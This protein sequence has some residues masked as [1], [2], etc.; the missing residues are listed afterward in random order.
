M[1]HD[2]PKTKNYETSVVYRGNTTI[3][4]PPGT[5]FP[6]IP[7]IAQLDYT[8]VDLSFIP[9]YNKTYNLVNTNGVQRSSVITRYSGPV[10]LTRPTYLAYDMSNNLYGTNFAQASVGIFD[11]TTGGFTTI[12]YFS[13]EPI[14]AQ[15]P[16]P[17]AIAVSPI[18]PR[19][20]YIITTN[21]EEN[22]T[23]FIKKVDLVTRRIFNVDITGSGFA[24]LSGLAFDASGF[25]YSCDVV[26]NNILRFEITSENTLNNNEPVG[27]G[28]AI[29]SIIASSFSGIN[30]PRDLTCDRYNNI[31]V[32]NTNENNILKITPAYDVTIISNTNLVNPYGIS[33]NYGNDM[34]YI[35]NYGVI[36]KD[37]PGTTLQPDRYTG[38]YLYVARISNDITE[39][40]FLSFSDI[41][42]PPP[43]RGYYYYSIATDLL[44]N[45]S[46]SAASANI[47]NT[48]P[49][50]S[51]FSLYDGYSAKGLPGRF[52]GGN[53][54]GG[55]SPNF[56]YINPITSV[57][58]D[59]SQ[60]YLYAAEYRSPF[61]TE[62]PFDDEYPV[63]PSGI[64]WK[65]DTTA[66]TGWNSPA[67]T[68]FYPTFPGGQGLPSDLALNNPTSIAF[69]GSGN[70]YVGNAVDNK[71]VVITSTANGAEVIITG[72][73]LT[74]PT[75]L[76]FDSS[77]N[78][79]LVNF[80]DNTLCKLEFSNT[81]TA[82]STEL[83]LVGSQLNKP[84]A[85]TFNS[86]FTKLF[87]ANQGSNNILLV[88]PISL[89]STIYNNPDSFVNLSSPSGLAYDDNTGI[90][91]IS[92]TGMN[93][94]AI[95]TNNGNVNDL[96][97]IDGSSVNVLPEDGKVEMITPQGLAI[98]VCSNIYVANYG[99]T[100]DAILK[101]TYDP[102]N[103]TIYNSQVNGVDEAKLLAFD[104]KTNYVYILPNL[105]SN[106]LSIVT[107]SNEVI[108]YGE[109]SA[110]TESLDFQ[111]TNAFD[112]NSQTY[113][114]EPYDP[115][116][117]LYVNGNLFDSSGPTSNLWSIIPDGANHYGDLAYWNARPVTITGYSIPAETSPDFS[118]TLTFNKGYP[119]TTTPMAY[120]TLP[121]IGGDVIVEIKLTDNTNAVIR[122]LPI[123]GYIGNY[124]PESVLFNNS[125][126]RM[127]I[128]GKY[129]P[130]GNPI[131]YYVD[132]FDDPLA[133]NLPAQPFITV[134]SVGTEGSGLSIIDRYNFIY[135]ATGFA[136]VRITDASGTGV[137]QV[138]DYPENT[139]FT[140][141]RCLV[142]NPNENSIIVS[143]VTGGV[144]QKIPLSFNFITDKSNTE[145]WGLELFENT[146]VVKETS[147]LVENTFVFSFDIYT[148]LIW[149]TPAEP[150]SGVDIAT[151]YFTTT[152]PAS[153]EGEPTPIYPGPTDRYYLRCNDTNISNIFCNNC[154]YNKTKFLSG[155]YPVSL[156]ISPLSYYTY[157]ALQNNTIS[158]INQLGVVENSYIGTQYG[159]QN[160][161]SMTLDASYNMYVLNK[162]INGTTITTN[163]FLT[164]I[165][166]ENEVISA[167][168]IVSGID[169]PID[170]VF[171]RTNNVYV[172]IL[173]GNTPDVRITRYSLDAIDIQGSAFV[174]PI[175]F[176]DLYDP[177]GICVDENVPDQILMYITNTTQSGSHEIKQFYL[178]SYQSVPQYTIASVASLQYKGYK[179]VNKNDGK[180]YVNNKDNNSIMVVYIPS[181]VYAPVPVYVVP[182]ASQDI[183]VPSDIDFDPSGNLYVVNSGTSP[184][185]S[186]ISKIYI[187]YFNFTG[188]NLSTNICTATS[189][190]NIGEETNI[191][192]NY[193]DRATDD[194]FS[195]PLPNP[196]LHVYD[197]DQ[198][199]RDAPEPDD[200]T[201]GG[202]TGG[203]D[204]G[205]D[206]SEPP[207]G[208]PPDED[209]LVPPDPGM[210]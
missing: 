25:M 131:L 178:E 204:T 117:L 136:W 205:G 79:Y 126:S 195:W 208:P 159:L 37:Y 107:P 116:I 197:P 17:V 59:S 113:F 171:D 104:E 68:I 75:G 185:N 106:Y 157:V 9:Q 190:Y 35:A 193:P 141:I 4:P 140:D 135:L 206:G 172:Y 201:G 55:G 165:T 5:G 40:Y 123:T 146:L 196:S 203:G 153:I 162:N 71:L 80:K 183:V 169:N 88:S 158:R 11:L 164:K 181:V 76:S 191:I 154:T 16:I 101:V 60:S 83:A 184:R 42:T 95:I 160:I 187:E 3:P 186:R 130:F 48:T 133:T 105:I 142:Y 39:N 28:T 109:K 145:S 137:E 33:Y 92:N 138:L 156:V 63:Y 89:T 194:D 64:I 19:A 86:D 69:D 27:P 62:Y 121:D 98:D 209:D 128:V 26:T 85:T 31:Y 73:Q 189:I 188:V 50:I 58:L 6:L 87:I 29:A 45:I 110:Q 46:L 21:N 49:E 198:P 67:P 57:A 70:L 176:G 200:N 124:R 18:S 97:V 150:T 111:W 102:S 114:P 161:T 139:E 90:L 24:E 112:L 100:T 44:G 91:Y 202:D 47:I 129:D 147:S 134:G 53:S 54:T 84:C 82:T 10:T 132:N 182:W 77:G 199:T 41:D 144:L 38:E 170:V 210:P 127:Y 96:L 51:I 61:P 52:A 13:T 23:F 7:N 20:M 30:G 2:P 108:L 119:S 103:S 148:T 166:L 36:G 149:V 72:K 93:E 8:S 12:V 168:N 151:F 118:T 81:T 177:N 15:A 66:G 115:F 125:K 207:P 94:L 78:L 173:S 152:P 32:C 56:Y 1:Y 143:A 120:L 34:I 74:G 167:T 99:N 155:T 14:E 174:L 179:I 43:I 163:G 22:A 65:I 192:I 175:P 122:Q 180:L